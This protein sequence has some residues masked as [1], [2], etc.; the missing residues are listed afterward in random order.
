M[1]LAV[2]VRSLLPVQE[3]LGPTGVGRWTDGAL[4]A[5]ARAA[6][7]WEL[8][9][10][11]V[12]K[13]GTVDPRAFGP[14]ASFHPIR[15]SDRWQRRLSVVGL[16]PKID[17]SIGPHDVLLGPAF[18]TWR[19]DGAEIPVIHDL[20][21]VK[22]PEF[23]SPRNLW[24][25]R[26]MM[27]RSLERARLV[28][29]VSR[30]MREEICDHYR[31]DPERVA[32]VPNGYDP[33]AVSAAAHTP[34]PDEVPSDFLLFVGT[35]EPRKNLLGTLK[36]YGIA[37]AEEAALPPL[38][39]V[40]G[41]GWRDEPI[42]EA[43]LRV[44]DGS[45]IETGYVS[46]ETLFAL[47][48]RARALVFPTFYEGFGLPVLE[49]M[50]CGCPVITS[51]VGGVPEVGGAAALYVDPHD[52]SDIAAAITKVMHD[53]ELRAT[54]SDR[55]RTQAARQTW[56]VAGEALRDACLRAVERA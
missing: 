55:G 40:G 22:N 26:M 53:D 47:Y 36:A 56:D 17:R 39:V 43:L 30:A 21:Y 9:L 44:P 6:P 24:F 7:D 49:A 8:V 33:V 51:A 23:V 54:L 10:V 50:A 38:V 11:L 2:D 25:M 12:H 15:M 46:D 13:D 42:D 18:V 4:R 1:R 14:N 29:T 35:K 32:V 19:S 27:P 3:G 34:L 20:T 41:R 52:P 37:A 45:V 31:L 5:L 48:H 16:W 28:V